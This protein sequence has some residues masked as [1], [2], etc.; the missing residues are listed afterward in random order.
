MGETLTRRVGFLPIWA[1]AL[2]FVIVLGVYLS[3]RKNKAAAAAAAANQQT[4]SNLSSNLGTVPVSNLT[5]AAQPMPI[6]LGDTFVST[7]I[8]QS[9]NVSPSTTVNNQL[10]SYT[11]QTAPLPAPSPGVC[12][13]GM[14]PLQC[15]YAEGGGSYLQALNA[16]QNPQTKPG[17]GSGL[18]DLLRLNPGLLSANT[19][20]GQ[21]I[22]GITGYRV[23]YNGVPL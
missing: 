5:T 2:A 4:T 8:P 12:E 16:Q 1:W 17:Y 10:P 14:N 13:P 22:P 19:P 7:T 6:Q 20:G 23:S 21:N 11:M 9:V 15:A 18:A 3:Y